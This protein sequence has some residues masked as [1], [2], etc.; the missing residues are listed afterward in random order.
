MKLEDVNR[1]LTQIGDTE[2]SFLLYLYAY[3][4]SERLS[5]VYR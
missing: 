5:S 2:D 4:T 1:I 3:F